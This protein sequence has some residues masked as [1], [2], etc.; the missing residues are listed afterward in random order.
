MKPIP[1]LGRNLAEEHLIT[2]ELIYRL[3]EY[4]HPKNVQF[5]LPEGFP[6]PDE[7]Y[8]NYVKNYAFVLY[9]YD[10]LKV[11]DG[12]LFDW[13]DDLEADGL[14]VCWKML[15]N[16]VPSKTRP[17]VVKPLRQEVKDALILYL[18]TN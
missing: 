4:D 5:G 13:L 11:Y 8:R 15:W 18:L 14:L 1:F 2:L 7:T 9:D 17:R 16:G 6:Y 3:F 12:F 10:E